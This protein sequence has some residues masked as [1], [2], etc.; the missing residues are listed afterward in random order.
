MPKIKKMY[1]FLYTIL[2]VAL[3]SIYIQIMSL[4][5][6]LL[7][8]AEQS[9]GIFYQNIKILCYGICAIITTAMIW[10][11]SSYI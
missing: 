1:S 8:N 3:I 6:S 4:T 11:Y 5:E 10:Y 7:E 2:G 9:N